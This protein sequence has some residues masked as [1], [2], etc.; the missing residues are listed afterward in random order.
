MDLVCFF[1][2][3]LSPRTLGSIHSIHFAWMHPG[4]RHLEN[5]EFVYVTFRQTPGVSP[6]VSFKQ[7]L[8]QKMNA[9]TR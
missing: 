8:L 5:K 4:T 9:Q 3:I 7:Q 1:V 2:F 6:V